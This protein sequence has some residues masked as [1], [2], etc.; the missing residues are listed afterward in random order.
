[1][2]DLL[3]ESNGLSE[4]GP[5]NNGVQTWRV[6][7]ITQDRGESVEAT[8]F[9]FLPDIE[10]NATLPLLL[11]THPL[12]GFNDACAPTAIG[13]EGAAVP[14]L[15]S[16]MGLVVAAPDY[17]G[18]RGYGEGSSQIHP[19]ILAEP[20]AIASLDSLRAA[21]QLAEDQESPAQPDRDRTLLWGASEGGFA[22]LWSDRYWP[23]YAPEFNNI[24]VVA[25]IPPTDIQALATIATADFSPA[26]A[27]LA[28]IL[29]GMD[30]WYE[31]ND[32][33][34]VLNESLVTV[35]PD[36]MMADC[37]SFPSVNDASLPDDF[38]DTSF[39]TTIASDDWES[40]EPWSC[41]LEESSLVPS[42]VP[43]ESDAPVLIITA[44]NDDLA[45]PEPV[46]TDIPQ[47]CA[48]GY[49]I[50]HVQ[51]AG[52]DHVAGAVD[53]LPVQF[54]WLMDRIAGEPPGTT[55]TVSEPQSCGAE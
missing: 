21:V 5:V 37:S 12:M 47:L 2:I 38:F 44:E 16:A 11:Y 52:A 13:L 49:A 46:H 35:L 15:M 29:I 27:A 3:L 17:L 39:I 9:V 40:I 43:Y 53:T 45:W 50:E 7:Y 10:T 22:A 1:M 41:F 48:Q 42:R 28:A 51:C 19:A 8:G 20:T 25:A 36:E 31:V 33:T 24:G 30:Q 23:R 34:G 54:S 55:C 4:Y 18:M 14:L 26:T 6:R 32:L